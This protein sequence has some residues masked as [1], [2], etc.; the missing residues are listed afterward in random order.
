[1]PSRSL[2]LNGGGQGSGGMNWDDNTTDAV[3]C[4]ALD[5]AEV[6]MFLT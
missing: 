3:L 6:L 4:K 2:W 1:M 5:R